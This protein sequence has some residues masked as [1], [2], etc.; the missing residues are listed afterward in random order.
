[1]SQQFDIEDA[2]RLRRMGRKMVALYEKLDP[3]VARSTAHLPIS[4]KAGCAGCCYLLA[5]ISLPEGVAIAEYFLED[6]QRR[7]LIPL[8]MRSF[9][10]QI[11]AMPSGTLTFKE[12]REAYFAKK[13]PCTFLD[14]ETNLCTIYPVR[15]GACRYHLVVTDPKLCM[16]E[17]G[18]QEVARA[19]TLEADGHLFSEANRVSNQTKMPLFVAPLPVMMLWAFKLLIEGRKAFEDALKDENLGTMSLQGWTELLHVREAMAP[20]PPAPGETPAQNSD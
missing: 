15:P 19:N 8:L 3:A 13:V 10:E 4:C 18:P 1:M 11:Q 20:P 16:P 5:L 6:T 12:I 17:A 14:T 2:K 7:N 9:Y